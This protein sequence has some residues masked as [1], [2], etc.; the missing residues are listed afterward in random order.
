MRKW[1]V[2]KERKLKQIKC[3]RPTVVIVER[4]M[5]RILFCTPLNVPNDILITAYTS[6]AG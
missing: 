5:P 2:I 3:I 4:G 6:A 1:S